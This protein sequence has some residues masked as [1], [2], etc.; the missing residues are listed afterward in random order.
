MSSPLENLAAS[1]TKSASTVA[2]F[3]RQTGHAQPSFAPDAPARFPV[4]AGQDVVAA[5]NELIYAARQLQFLAL[6]PT[7]SLQWF[8]LTGVSAGG[9]PL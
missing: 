4:D 7:E 1:I 9:H 2:Q 8:A 5:R 6:G 3:L